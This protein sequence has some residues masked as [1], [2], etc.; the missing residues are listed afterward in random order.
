[1]T[2]MEEHT[3]V[4]LKSQSLRFNVRF[5]EPQPNIPATSSLDWCLYP[6]VDPS[7]INANLAG[8]GLPPNGALCGWD[9]LCT[10]ERG[11]E[12]EHHPGALGL[13][14]PPCPR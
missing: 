9:V 3:G 14:W 10:N 7:L 2:M 11:A 1:M 13:H 6:G 4:G 5:G 8:E 12:V